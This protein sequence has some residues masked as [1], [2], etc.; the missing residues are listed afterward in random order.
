MLDSCPDILWW[1]VCIHETFGVGGEVSFLL[2][3]FNQHLV[4]LRLMERPG[5]LGIP[6]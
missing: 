1:L 4:V 3:N 2:F 6:I 5:G